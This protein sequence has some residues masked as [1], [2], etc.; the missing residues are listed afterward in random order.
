MNLKQSVCCPHLGRL[1]TETEISLTIQA[2]SLT[3]LAQ[4]GTNRS[5]PVGPLSYTHRGRHGE[6]I[7][8]GFRKHP[9]IK[10]ASSQLRKRQ[11]AEDQQRQGKYR[12]YLITDYETA[13]SKGREETCECEDTYFWIFLA[14]QIILT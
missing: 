6:I 2:T 11:K 10:A 9:V 14:D 13:A 1:T 5:A 3:S 4:N 12:K 7:S 8:S